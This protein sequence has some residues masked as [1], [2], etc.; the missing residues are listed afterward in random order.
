MHLLE[1]SRH[2]NSSHCL[3]RF[4]N[5]CGAKCLFR[6]SINRHTGENCKEWFH[7]EP[8]W[9]PCRTFQW[10]KESGDGA[11]SH[12]QSW[13]S[14]TELK[15]NEVLKIFIATISKVEYYSHYHCSERMLLSAV[16]AVFDISRIKMREND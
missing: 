5:L 16:S 1:S 15:G 11:H 13:N 2:A 10:V 14:D 9:L 6:Y 12:G 4:E 7:E 8:M 3:P